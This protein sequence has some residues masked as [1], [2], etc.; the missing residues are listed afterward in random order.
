MSLAEAAFLLS[1]EDHSNAK[2]DSE[3]LCKELITQG[4]EKD[5]TIAVRI[6]EE[7]QLYYPQYV[8]NVE[9]S[10]FD[11]F[12]KRIHR[13]AKIACIHTP[14]IV[15]QGVQK[16]ML[17]CAPGSKMYTTNVHDYGSLGCF[18]KKT[19]GRDLF[20]STCEH[21]RDEHNFQMIVKCDS[22]NKFKVH[23]MAGIKSDTADI[24][25]LQVQPLMQHYGIVNDITDLVNCHKVTLKKFQTPEI[26]DAVIKQGACTGYSEMVIKED[27]ASCTVDGRENRNCW[28]LVHEENNEIA[29]E[30]DS[31]SVVVKPDTVDNSIVGVLFATRDDGKGALMF[32]FEEN[33]KELVR[34]KLLY[35][36]SFSLM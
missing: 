22:D 12:E 6:N 26:G 21:C 17:A 7:N 29:G 35:R 3:S 27:V 5:I 8:I 25:L 14:I 13:A 15:A 9:V 28:R 23:Y 18:L 19:S 10:D 1:D 16:F 2:T 33:I 30:G 36:H 31:G 32:S 34:V 24:C 20:V 4:I 11:E